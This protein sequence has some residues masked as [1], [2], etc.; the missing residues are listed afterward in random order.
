MARR[1]LG[2]LCWGSWWVFSAAQAVQAAPVAAAP[3]RDVTFVSTSDSHYKA[4]ESR[5]W[6]EANRETIREINALSTLRW[7][8]KLGGEAIDKPRG[9]LL[10]GDCID[11]GDKV[12][13]GKD[14]TAEQYKAFVADFGLDGEDGLLKFRV[15]ETWGNHDGPPIGKSTQSRL[16]FRARL[17]KRN[18]LRKSAGCLAGLSANGLHYSWDWSDVHLVS[19]GIYPADRQNAKVRYNATWHDPQGALTFLKRD[20][21]RC[22]GQ[23]G[24]PVVLTAHCGFDTNW[25]HADDWKAFYEAARAYN[26][27]LYLYGHTGTGLR[28][29]AP[30]GETKKW[31]CINDGQ[32]TSS[33]FVIQIVG[34]RLRAA[35]R[36]KENVVRH[37]SRDGSEYRQWSGQWGWKFLLD[38]KISAP[39]AKTVR[40]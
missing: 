14:Y 40:R 17:K 13:D 30:A 5:D 39:K 22:V 27:V 23:S 1:L 28:D 26:V 9:V 31:T 19:L 8:K 32:T 4:F 18:A 21:A 3:E 2:V 12:R 24:R 33:F 36:R 20:L 37:R 7:P 35:C 10:L 38:R 16:N 34:N 29:W 6:N 25:W 15:Y 11:D